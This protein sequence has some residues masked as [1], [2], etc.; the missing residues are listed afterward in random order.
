DHSRQR[1]LPAA[2]PAYQRHRLPPSDL[3]R[4]V[5]DRAED[6]GIP[7]QRRT[8]V[9]IV[10][11]DIADG[12]EKAGCGGDALAGRNGLA[13]NAFAGGSVVTPTPNPSPQG[14]GGLGRNSFPY[15]ACRGGSSVFR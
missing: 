12:K 7:E 15:R 3:E 2:R 1:G 10:A 9:R 5:I 6:A 11:D 13:G 14:G 4:H 8:A